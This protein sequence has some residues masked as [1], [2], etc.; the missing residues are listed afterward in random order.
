MSSQQST[1][2]LFWD[3]VSDY[4]RLFMALLYINI[5]LLVLMAVAIIL[6]ALGTEAYVISV[7]NVVLLSG[8]SILIGFVTWR[9]KNR[10]D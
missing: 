5:T 3:I 7:I 9:S 8:T 6:G 4:H 1:R 2:E 10:G